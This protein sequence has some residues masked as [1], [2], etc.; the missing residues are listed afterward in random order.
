MSGTRGG[1]DAFSS[2]A[3][4]LRQI[5]K[6]LSRTYG[7]QNW[8]PADGP[9]EVAVGAVLT[10]N[11]AWANVERAIQNLKKAGALNPEAIL[12][13]PPQALE[14][15]IQ[16]AGFFRAKARK[17]KALARWWL[18]WAGKAD[19]TPTATLRGSLLSL[20]G[21]GP[22]TADSILLYA[23]GRP[24]FVVD[25]YTRRVLCRHGLIRKNASYEEIQA[26]FHEFIPPEDYG[27][28]HALLVRVG[29]AHC[30][31]IPRC[32]GCP[33]LPLLG[34]PQ[35]EVLKSNRR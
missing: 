9:F 18:R 24:V 3:E 15:W 29:K 12:K 33:L 6:V 7:P 1:S 26:P 5:Y 35:E 31:K 19:P 32:D 13:A 16:P 34:E 4:R 8:W 2:I 22:E 21:I 23:F 28:Y 17:L 10:Q 14:R 11:T 30:R 27:E 25:E 20:W